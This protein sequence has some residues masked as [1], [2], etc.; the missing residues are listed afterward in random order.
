MVKEENNLFDLVV[1]GGGINGTGIARDA[2]GRNLRVLLCERDDLASGTS[3]ASTKL[4]HGGLRYL[5]YK[6]F[7]LVKESLKEREVL[8]N[9]APHIIWPMRFILPHIPELRPFW[10]VRAGLFLYDFMAGR[11]KLKASK[12]INLRKNIF[13]KNLKEKFK[14]AFIYSDCWVQDSR[15]VVLNAVDA[16]NKGAEIL[17]R[18]SCVMTTRKKDSWEVVLR[19][20]KTGKTR[21]VKTTNL[22]NAA[23]PWVNIVQEHSLNQKNFN[24]ASLVKGSHIIIPRILENDTGFIFQ[25]KDRR[26]IFALPFENKFTLIGTTEENFSDLPNNAKIS[27]NE[28]KYLLDSVNNYFSKEVG[29]DEIIWSYSG[30]RQLMPSEKNVTAASRDYKL[31]I[32]NKAAP[33]MT[34]YG[35]KITTYRKLSENAVSLL[36]PNSKAWTAKAKLPGGNFKEFNK[37]LEDFR[38]KFPF[39]SKE[40][41]FRYA[42]NYGNLAEKFLNDAKSIDMLGEHFGDGVFECELDYLMRFEWAQTLDDIIWR[43]SKLGLTTSLDTK[44]KI[45]T[46][47]EKY[48]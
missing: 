10:Q 22:V 47:L 15:L 25:N 46:W 37:Y 5:E 44:H 3:S 45:A 33:L 18:T 20:D 35:G 36:F 29:F 4:I 38:K 26:V 14:N 9:S 39:L 8:L 23:G 16:R 17:T 2:A 31:E 42:R 21:V 11:K 12:S 32:D 7:R 6:E 43:R 30:V 41:S 27:E 1:I 48:N 34:V 13:G 24:K 28:I 40:L 19:L